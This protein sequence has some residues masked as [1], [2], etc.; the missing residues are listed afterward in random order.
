MQMWTQTQNCKPGSTSFSVQY[1]TKNV[2]DEVRRI[3]VVFYSSW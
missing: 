3:V 2:L 1:I